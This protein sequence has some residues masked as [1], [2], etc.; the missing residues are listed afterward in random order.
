M[1]IVVLGSGGWGTALALVL[2]QNRHQ[3]T[4]WSH[5]QQ[6]AAQMELKRENPLLLGVRLPETLAVTSGLNCVKDAELV[7]F[8]SPSFA[9]RAVAHEAAPYLPDGA[10]LLSVTKGIERGTHLRMSQIIAQETGGGHPIAVLSGPSHAEEVARAMPTGVVAASGSEETA[11]LI[12]RTFSNERFRVYTHD[13]MV[14]V[15]LAGALKN[16][17]ALCCGVSDG[18]GLGDNTKALLITRAMAETSRLAERLGGRKETLAGLAGMGDLIVTCTSMHS[19]NHRAGIAIGEGRTPQEVVADMGGVV[20]GYY[21]A[22]SAKELSDALGVEMP[23]CEAMYDILYKG[24]EVGGMVHRLMCR[25]PK[26]E[27]DNGWV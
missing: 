2:H 10:A 11:E 7:V 26:R 3:V 4:L 9:L 8:A 23:I 24:A 6:K 21:A 13:D 14:G 16:V 19:R 27:T 12:Q 5:D 18:L 1:N 17:A 22:V 20:E 25:A 15:E